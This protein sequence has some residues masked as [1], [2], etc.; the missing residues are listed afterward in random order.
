MAECPIIENEQKSRSN[1]VGCDAHGDE[2]FW[3]FADENDGY[4]DTNEIGDDCP[5]VRQDKR[6]QVHD[7][8]VPIEEQE[9]GQGSD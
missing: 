9:I 7:I 4:R 6:L 2:R 3:G 1:G 5:Q 8:S